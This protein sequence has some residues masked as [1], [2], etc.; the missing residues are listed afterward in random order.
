MIFVRPLS[1]RDSKPV[2]GHQEGA[3]HI[4]AERPLYLNLGSG[5]DAIPG[6]VNVDKSLTGLLDRIPPPVKWLSTKAGVLSQA[7]AEVVWD[8]SIQRINL[9]RRF[10]WPKGSV[11]AI[12]T[13]HF[14]EHL[15]PR[16]ARS[17]LAQCFVALRPGGI[18]RVCLPDLEEGA[19]KYLAEKEQGHELAADSF[20]GFLYLAPEPPGNAFRRLIVK[21]L[22]RPHGWMYDAESCAVRLRE[23]GFLDITRCAAGQGMCPDVEVLDRRPESFFIE[24][25]TPADP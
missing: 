6:W 1:S 7:Q 5:P 10:P 25:R 23:T 13:S 16:V 21:L 8:P 15:R 18:I 2:H 9:T 14:L 3:S 4:D 12:Y 19:R 20:L 17:L 11:E 22:H 24:A